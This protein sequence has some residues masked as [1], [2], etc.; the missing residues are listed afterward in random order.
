MPARKREV[1]ADR[2]KTLIAEAGITKYRL[3][4]LSGVSKQ[5]LSKL[6]AGQ[7]PGWETVMRL[8]KA[9]GVSLD[10]FA[11]ELSMPEPSEPS[12]RGRPK[13]TPAK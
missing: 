12:P 7:Q 2:L 1:F 6:E 8:A 13:K 5:T 11:I 4:Q 3:S 9:L 10:A